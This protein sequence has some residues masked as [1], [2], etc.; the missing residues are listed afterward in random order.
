MTE[1]EDL[2]PGRA[3]D[4]G[5]GEGADALWLAAHGW[6]VTAVDIAGAALRHAREQAASAGDSVS[7]RID[8]EEAD[9]AEWTPAEAQFDLVSSHYVH[10]AGSRDVP[11]RRLAAAVAPGGTLLIVGH[12]PAD[13]HTAGMH[14]SAPE[15]HFTAEQIAAGLDPDRWDIVAAESRSRTVTGHGG[16]EFP[17]RDAVLHA[18]KRG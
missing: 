4:A 12:D 2:A 11:F 10:P 13:P 14:D 16:Q 1:V 5:C 17:M 18:R 3:L 9:L 6:Q 15:V 7:G 8:W